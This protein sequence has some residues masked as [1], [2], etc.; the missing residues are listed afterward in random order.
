L[1][2][3]A[4]R[5]LL[6]ARIMY[7]YRPTSQRSGRKERVS[8]KHN[9]VQLPPKAKILS[10]AHTLCDIMLEYTPQVPSLCDYRI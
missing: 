3:S 10:C 9:M 8:G 1:A 2:M 7:I 6:P 4:F 5:T